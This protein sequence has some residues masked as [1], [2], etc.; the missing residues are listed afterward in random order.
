[1]LRLE[2]SI[3]PLACGDPHPANNMKSQPIVMMGRL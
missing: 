1:V 3:E 2:V